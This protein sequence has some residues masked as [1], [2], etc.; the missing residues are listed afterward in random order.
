MAL[1]RLQMATE[2]LDN[3]AR[4]PTGQTRSGTALSSRVVTWLNRAQTRIA[5]RYDMLYDS[6][7]LST[8]ASTSQYDFPSGLS[9]MLSMRL[10]DGLASWKLTCLMPWEFD[11]VIAN[12]SAESENK[13][14]FY[15]PNK[16]DGTFDLFPVPDAVYSIARRFTVAPTELTA[17]DQT[18]DYAAVGI[19]LDDAIVW[20]ATAE[21]YAWMQEMNDAKYWEKRGFE[22]AR[23]IWR[24]VRG[25]FPDWTPVAKPF[26]TGGPAQGTYTGN[27]YDN[28]MVIRDLS[29]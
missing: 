7:T 10:Q 14:R 26:R 23:E 25:T 6:D 27:M 28:P 8:V 2:V 24:S 12:P 18:T 21:G 11:R 19:D 17:D 9:A 1:T 13:P 15:I 20:L 16:Y 5:R 4:S 3:L 22:E 29:Y